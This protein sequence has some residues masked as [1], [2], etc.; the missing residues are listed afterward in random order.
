MHKRGFTII[1]LIIIIGI[2]A[3]LFFMA[4]TLAAPAAQ[5]TGNTQ[6]KADVNALL[7]AIESYK[8]HTNNYPQGITTQ[9]KTIA[10]S[11]GG[12]K[13]DLCA[14]LVPGYLSNLPTDPASG[15]IAPVGGKCTDKNARYNTGYT[16]QLSADNHLTVSAP[17]AQGGETIFASN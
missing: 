6:R 5:R 9:A 17:A 1:E 7:T 3:I 4:Y 15:S 11:K 2:L 13:I 12:D 16:V 14:A 8:N 10:S